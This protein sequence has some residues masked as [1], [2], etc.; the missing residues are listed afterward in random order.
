MIIPNQGKTKI[1]TLQEANNLFESLK[2]QTTRKSE[3]K[4]Y[5]KFNHIL[6]AFIEE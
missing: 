6:L 1:M 2:T 4:V 3:I 5:E